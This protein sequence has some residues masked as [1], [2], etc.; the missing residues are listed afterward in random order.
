MTM[1]RRLNFW[2]S[3]ELLAAIEAAASERRLNRSA[4]ARWALRHVLS[5]N[6][7]YVYEPPRLPNWQVEAWT[8]LLRGLFGSERLV[9]TD[10]VKTLLVEAV[11]MLNKRD[12]QVLTRRFGLAGPR[13][14]LE[15]IGDTMG[16]YRSRIYQIE[17]QALQRLQ[18]WLQ[19][20]GIWK[21]VGDQLD[22]EEKGE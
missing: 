18:G 2:V 7:P 6:D 21:M 14:T 15:E 17:T 16:V 19:H 22:K 12:R 8:S 11:A 13:Y 3:A 4:W 5:E 1:S 9:L 20:R 10:E